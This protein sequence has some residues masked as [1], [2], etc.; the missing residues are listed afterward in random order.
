VI[1]LPG[2]F[3]QRQSASRREDIAFHLPTKRTQSSADVVSREP[4]TG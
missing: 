3:R 2:V 1:F 4:H